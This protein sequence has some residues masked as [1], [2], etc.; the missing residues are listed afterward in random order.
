MKP[1][2]GRLFWKLFAALWFATVLAF[3]VAKTYFRLTGQALPPPPPPR[4]FFPWLPLLIGISVSVTFSA[5]VAWYLSGPIRDL[6]WG[7]RRAAEERFD[8]RLMPLMG[9][10]RDEMVDLATEFDAMAARLQQL[11]ENRRTLL[12]DL[13]HELR[14]PLARMQV[15]VGLWRQ[16]PDNGAQLAG[17]VAIEVGR[18]DAL[19]DE[20]LTLHRLE[21]ANG[22]NGDPQVLDIIDLCDVLESI[23]AD[24]SFEARLKGCEVSLEGIESFVAR[25]NGDLIYRAIEN[26]V[27]NAVN[28]APSGS[29]VEINAC[30][31][32]EGAVLRII[33]ADRGPGVPPDM[34]KAIFEPF[35]R[36][37]GGAAR[38]TGLG[39][40]LAR[41]AVVLHGG[42]IEAEVRSGGGLNVEIEIPVALSLP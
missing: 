41:R 21:S 15:A 40:A 26:V 28:H 18:L 34:L 19:V 13:S 36:I 22:V 11:T 25:V 20:L 3:I 17:R 30:L 2:I 1:P 6:R 31:T 9:T 8:T 27:R 39:L 35:V 7:L 14:S 10:R 32:G 33:V 12:H 42:R 23:V 29:K 24:A 5:I 38:G 4:D 37:D 16:A